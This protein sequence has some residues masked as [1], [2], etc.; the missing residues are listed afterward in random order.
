VKVIQSALT[1]A[2]VVQA[3]AMTPPTGT[4]TGSVHS[5]S[6]AAS[7]SITMRFTIR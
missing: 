5:S 1:T 7:S 6:G 4:A 3:A 2:S